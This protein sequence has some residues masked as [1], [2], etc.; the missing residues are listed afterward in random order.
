[1]SR[2]APLQLNKN[3]QLLMS[4]SVKLHMRQR[5]NRSAAPLLSRNVDLYPASLAKL[6]GSLFA[7]VEEA[8]ED[9]ERAEERELLAP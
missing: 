2:S 6:F 1:M 7:Q 3:V 8:M 9:W 4:S 5:M